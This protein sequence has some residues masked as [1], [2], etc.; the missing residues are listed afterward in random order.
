MIKHFKNWLHRDCVEVAFGRRIIR[1]YDELN[2]ELVRRHNRA[3]KL[4]VQNR[5]L[6]NRIADLEKEINTL[7][8]EKELLRDQVLCVEA[9]EAERGL[10]EKR[11]DEAKDSLVDLLDKER[12]AA[13]IVLPE[14]VDD[15]TIQT[16]L[17]L[18][19]RDWGNHQDRKVSRDPSC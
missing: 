16:P 11:I 13:G 6:F 10:V 15:G 18:N 12:K 4:A 9:L 8:Q 5:D 3:E 1:Q 17:P 2:E 14:D 7:T 19:P